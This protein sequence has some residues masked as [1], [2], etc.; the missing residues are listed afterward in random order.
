[1]PQYVN[2]VLIPLTDPAYPTV[3]VAYTSTVGNTATLPPGPNCVWILCTTAAFVM[4]G[5]DVEATATNGIPVGAGI[6]VTLKVPAGTGAPWRV[7]AIQVS[8]GGNVYV[9]ALAN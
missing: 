1:M 5:E 2:E 9:K 6:P 8:S 3:T 4:V 7:S